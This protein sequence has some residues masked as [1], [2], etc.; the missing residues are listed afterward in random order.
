MAARRGAMK[1]LSGQLSAVR[2]ARM[3]TAVGELERM[4][5]V[6]E[7]EALLA[8]Q[9][10][11]IALD[12]RKAELELRMLER[13]SGKGRISRSSLDAADQEGVPRA[14]VALRGD[15][16]SAWNRRSAKEALRRC[17]FRRQSETTRLDRRVRAPIDTLENGPDCA[18]L[19]R[20]VDRRRYVPQGEE[21]RRGAVGAVA[22]VGRW[23]VTSA[24]LRYRVGL[25][26]VSLAKIALGT[27]PS[28]RKT[29]ESL[30]EIRATLV[31]T[32]TGSAGR[33]PTVMLAPELTT[34]QRRAV[35][36][37]DLERWFPDIL[38]CMTSRPVKP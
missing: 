38:S 3:R 30:A 31:R 26:L 11:D 34:G 10:R 32:T 35:R 1:R 24:H 27:D 8:G 14:S 25:M 23:I 36:V 4:L 29:M 19:P 21:R 2:A 7:S 20:P 33:R 17:R 15:R 22:S 28:V 6:V 12:L 5:V 13:L 16:W 9:K 37:F 18:C